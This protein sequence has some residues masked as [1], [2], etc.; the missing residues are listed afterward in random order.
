MKKYLSF[1]L[2]FAILATLCSCGSND[3][4][5]AEMQAQIDALYLQ[6]NS[7]GTNAEEYEALQA[8]NEALKA[9]NEALK[10]ELAQL[11]EDSTNQHS[12][13]G[14][15]QQLIAQAVNSVIQSE[16]FA[17]WQ[18]LYTHFT[19]KAPSQ[20]EVIN[21]IH[22]QIGDFEN[23]KMDCYLVNLAADIG[24]WYNEEAEQGS[25]ES[26]LFI[27]VDKQ[28]GTVYDSIST[29]AMSITHDVSTDEG[30][31]TYLLWT[32]GSSQ[33]DSTAETSLLNSSEVISPLLEE[34]IAYIN[35][36][37]SIG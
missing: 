27:F 9:E 29:N 17:R 31:A 19:T 12:T 6:L 11:K 4:Q 20:P 15:T 34:D 25:V 1:I 14:E 21:A 18:E 24:Y 22:Y 13:A 35:S 8:E 26:N 5:F 23:E 32:Y 3:Q 16:S 28:T 7:E 30:R 33:L 10:A 37:L 36:Q 2:S